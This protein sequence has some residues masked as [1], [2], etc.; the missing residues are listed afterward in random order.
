MSV[1]NCKLLT[2]EIV[3]QIFEASRLLRVV[4]LKIIKEA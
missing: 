4:G 2:P 1:P 3:L